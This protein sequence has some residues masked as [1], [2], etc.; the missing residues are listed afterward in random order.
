M[1][2]VAQEMAGKKGIFEEY[3]FRFVQGEHPW[4]TRM[5]SVLKPEAKGQGGVI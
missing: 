3:E 1:F 5:G 2:H 4:R